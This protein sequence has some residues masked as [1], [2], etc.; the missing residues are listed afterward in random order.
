MITIERISVEPTRAC[1]KGCSFCYNGSKPDGD[2]AWTSDELVELAR[3]CADHGVRALSIGGGEPTEWPGLAPTLRALE[4]ILARTLTTHGIGVDLRALAALRPDKV[5]VSIHAPENPREVERVAC[6]TR[7]LEQLGVPS[8]VNL[9]VR[10][11]R[12]IEAARAYRT[13]AARGMRRVVL[14]PMRGDTDET[15]SPDELAAI[16]GGPFQSVSC[17]RGCGKSERFV[18]IGADRTVAWCSYTRARARLE[19]PTYEALITAIEGLGLV[20]CGANLVKLGASSF[21]HLAPSALGVRTNRVARR[22]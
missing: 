1:S 3:S 12:L 8:G 21:G 9:L 14:L 5:H 22:A 18:S 20:F 7:E 13:L 11:S 19:A 10:R 16:A 4:G 6:Q 17:L 2:G 15:P